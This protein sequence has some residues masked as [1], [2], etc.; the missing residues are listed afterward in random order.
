ML[1]SA[2]A[3]T[4]TDTRVNRPSSVGVPLPVGRIRCRREL[5]GLAVGIILAQVAHAQTIAET[6]ETIKEVLKPADMRSEQGFC[7]IATLRLGRTGD[8]EGKSPCVLLENGKPLAMPGALHADIR[9]K[10]EGR[11][12]HWT[13]TSLY[14]SASDNSDP[15]ANGREYALVSVRRLRRHAV[16]QRV[17]TAEASYALD[18]A[19]KS[20]RLDAKTRIETPLS[21]RRLA[22]RL[23]D[24][25]A[26]VIFKLAGKGWPDLTTAEG[27]LKSILRP[28]MTDEQKALA[29]WKF[30]VDWRYHYYPAEGGDE[31]HDPVK[32]VNVYGYGFCDDSASNFASLCMTA[33][34]RARTWGLSGH[35]VGEAFYG[36]GWHMFDPDHEVVYR[37]PDGHIASVEELAA[38]PEVITQTPRDPIGSDSASIAR[39]YTTT[40]DNKP[41]ER[42]YPIGHRLEPKL[43]PGDEVVFDFAER[44]AAHVVAFRDQPL[45]PKFGNGRLTRRLDLSRADREAEVRIEWPYVILGG[46]LRLTLAKPDAAIAVAL[47]ETPDK[48]TPLET[49]VAGT[50]LTAALD[51]WFDSQPRAHYAYTLRLTSK[52]GPLREAVREATLTTT[53]QFAPRALP[54]VQPGGVTVVWNVKPADG[55]ALP[56]DWRGLEIVHEWDEVLGDEPPR[57]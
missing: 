36:G 5:V 4:P 1:Q 40:E 50:T 8:K 38:H 3:D 22:A 37:M 17:T 47:V 10:G 9:T 18:A 54:Q 53:F 34:L 52:A 24:D 28:E 31:V 44:R 7:H 13:A 39:L 16:T 23:L 2:V 26:S 45:P 51:K 15:R 35:V 19:A 29:I 55:A 57:P 30:L 25:R 41:H 6:T 12:S 42:K 32:F 21:N 43:R 20:K 56:A 27:M 33:G 48:Q 14:F 46:G 11:H 49:K